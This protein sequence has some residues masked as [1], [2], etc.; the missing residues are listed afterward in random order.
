MQLL[1]PV[2]VIWSLHISSFA[3]QGPILRGVADQMK[4][5]DRQSGF[6]LQWELPLPTKPLVQVELFQA[7]GIKLWT[8]K[9]SRKDNE[10]GHR[11]QG[12]PVTRNEEQYND[13][14]VGQTIDATVR[15]FKMRLPNQR[16]GVLALDVYLA[17]GLWSEFYHLVQKDMKSNSDAVD[18][19]S[20]WL[21]TSCEKALSIAFANR[22]FEKHLH[23]VDVGLSRVVMWDYLAFAV[24]V[25]AKKWSDLSE[26]PNLGLAEP[27][28]CAIELHQLR[29]VNK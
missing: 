18:Q 25:S 10:R 19:K 1:L 16:L 14:M 7:T 22:G 9:L 27:V 12:E 5:P 13:E 23:A 24:D 3:A 28:L 4:R 11:N 17:K 26:L 8:L 21:K 20:L 2:I 15:W 6:D 29:G